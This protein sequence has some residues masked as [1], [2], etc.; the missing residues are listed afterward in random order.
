MKVF[1]SIIPALLVVTLLGSCEKGILNKKDKDMLAEASSYPGMVHLKTCDYDRVEA[2]TLINSGECS[3]Y[4][5]GA[6]EYYEKGDL[7]ARIAFG[8]SKEKEIDV[9]NE[10]GNYGEKDDWNSDDKKGCGD[11]DWGDKEWEDK[12]DEE[13]G[14]C[15]D[16]KGERKLNFRKEHDKDS[17]Y[18]K[19]VVEPLV[20]SEDCDYIVAGTVC[21]Y[22]DG[23]WV[24]TI[25]FGNGTCDDIATKT[26]KD[27][28][29]TFSLKDKKKFKK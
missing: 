8:D 19:V 13:S 18:D 20:K 9:E 5:E 24:A 10:C 2:E 4:Y 16:W 25:D 26:T 1:Q 11:M 21:F 12:K 29:K 23:Q 22:E 6:I 27:G 17:V 7:S 14:S 15:K 28:E 3:E